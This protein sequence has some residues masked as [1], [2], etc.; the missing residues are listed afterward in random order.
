MSWEPPWKR[1]VESLKAR[2]Y[3][4]PYLDRLSRRLEAQSKV[5]SSLGVKQLER[6]ILEEMAYALGRAEDKLNV[7][8]LELQVAGDEVDAAADDEE[9][10]EKLEAYGER[11]ARAERVRWEFLIHREA[12]GFRRH[13]DVDRFYP[14]PPRR[15]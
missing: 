2:D 1:L 10:A 15:R 11:W 4:S 3:E 5:R 6:E 12:L 14:L 9:R 13:E 8:L 7:A